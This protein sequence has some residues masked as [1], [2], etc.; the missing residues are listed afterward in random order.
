[1]TVRHEYSVRPFR[2]VAFIGSGSLCVL[3]NTACSGFLTGNFAPLFALIATPLLLLIGYAIQYAFL[4]KKAY[5]DRRENFIPDET[6]AYLPRA[7]PFLSF[8]LALLVGAGIGYGTAFVLGLFAETRSAFGELLLAFSCAVTAVWGHN[9]A[10]RRAIAFTHFNSHIIAEVLFPYAA[11]AALGSMMP[12]PFIGFSPMLFVLAFVSLCCYAFL[13]NQ[14][15]LAKL[16][17]MA[18]T[19]HITPKMILCSLRDLLLVLAVAVVAFLAAITLSTSLYALWQILLLIFVISGGKGG[20]I[21]SVGF[22]RAVFGSFPSGSI[23]LNKALFGV[24][25]VALL[26]VIFFL[27]YGR[28]PEI[29]AKIFEFFGKI[30]DKM[31]MKPSKR[32]AEVVAHREEM[33]EYSDYIAPIRTRKPKRYYPDSIREIERQ[34]DAITDGRE[35]LASAYRMMVE[36]LVRADVGV[37]VTDTPREIAAKLAKRGVMQDA[38][39][40]AR[41]FE[42]AAY[43]SQEKSPDG[44]DGHILNRM[45]QVI[46]IYTPR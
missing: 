39:E 15:A 18:T 46:R 22:D 33:T 28:I 24:G 38:A 19:C 29:R 34:L 11:C 20:E 7:L 2:C 41:A 37:S 4:D 32:R 10:A 25:C 8:L 42:W 31:M 30:G 21:A 26:I 1:M 14:L 44:V 6:V 27:T 36:R 35:K 5:R 45:M 9:T 23:P 16:S 12:E 13:Y 17:A 43:A 3:L 40:L